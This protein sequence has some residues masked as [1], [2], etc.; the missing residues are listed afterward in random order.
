MS[1]ASGAAETLV[2]S[3][4]VD[5][6]AVIVG[7]LRARRA[8]VALRRRCGTPGLRPAMPAQRDQPSGCRWAR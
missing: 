7:E 1:W 5:G 3:I 2:R 6:E 4:R 8:I